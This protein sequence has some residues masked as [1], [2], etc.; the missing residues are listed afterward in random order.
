MY[1]IVNSKEYNPFDREINI[2]NFKREL[3]FCKDYVLC[4][5]ETCP[6]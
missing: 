3:R 2:K 5:I 1:V 6:N 4:N